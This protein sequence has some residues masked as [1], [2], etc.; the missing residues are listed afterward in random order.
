MVADSL[1]SL[2][3]F[4][5]QQE[6]CSEGLAMSLGC[7]LGLMSGGSHYNDGNCYQAA[8]T[9]MTT[10]LVFQPQS[11]VAADSLEPLDASL[12]QL[13]TC[14]EGLVISLGP[15][16]R[17]M[18][19]RSE[20][21]SLPTGHSHYND[22]NCHQA[23]TI[24]PTLL[25]SQPQS[26]TAGLLS[27]SKQ[28]C[29]MDVLCHCQRNH[30]LGLLALFLHTAVKFLTLGA[31]LLEVT[32]SHYGFFV[33]KSLREILRL[34]YVVQYPCVTIDLHHKWYQVHCKMHLVLLT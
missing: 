16:L 27:L 13:E 30:L 15:E 5:S 11:S 9:S 1:E 31:L 18:F 34:I 12:S 3:A 4:I 26:L 21:Q 28:L 17:L 29:L 10:S 14:S 7:K 19:L 25:V 32:Y 22:G 8:H 33:R 24:E 6:T 20:R 23:H 2:D